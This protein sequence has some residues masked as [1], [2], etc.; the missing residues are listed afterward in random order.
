MAA[1]EAKVAEWDVTLHP[2]ASS[3][4]ATVRP[5]TPNV[6][7]N[8]R[9]LNL[10]LMIDCSG[11]MKDPI[12]QNV[13]GTDTSPRI[14]KWQAITSAVAAILRALDQVRR[15]VH[16]IAIFFGETAEAHDF[17]CDTDGLLRF[18]RDYTRVEG[19]TNIWA[20]ID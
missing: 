11:S 8:Q 5:V 3:T 18:M 16:I 4:V 10:V 15:P 6:P 12:E 14:T 13:Y 20:A 17:F 2:S 9:I 1:T 7:L 19:G